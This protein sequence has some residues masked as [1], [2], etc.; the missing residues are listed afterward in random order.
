MTRLI[1]LLTVLLCLYC[2]A[3]IAQCTVILGG[4]AC[5]PIE[6]FTTQAELLAGSTKVNC[7]HLSFKLNNTNCTGWTLKVRTATA[8]F[9]NG[10]N[11][12]P[13]H[14]VSLKFNA[15]TDGPS[16]GTLGY[17]SSP[18]PLST[19]EQSLVSNSPAPLSSP[20]NY[21]FEHLFTASITGGTHM[22]QSVNGSFATTLIFTLYNA[23]NQ[24]VATHSMPFNFQIYY[25]GPNLFDQCQG[26]TLNGTIT[27]P[28]TTFNTYAQIMSGLTKTEAVTVSYGLINNNTN[29]PNWTLKVRAASPNFSNGIQNIPVEKVSLR[30]NNVTGGP[31]A[32]DIGVA[33]NEIP[34]STAD[35]ILINR[36]NARLIAPPHGNVYHR[37]DAIVQGG[38]H[39][40]QPVNGAF[41][42]NLIF[43]LYDW[44]DQLVATWNS[45][46]TIQIYFNGNSLFTLTLQNGANSAYFNFANP[47]DI[48]N[49]ISLTKT[50]GLKITGY[51]NYQVFAQ[52]TNENLVSGSTS[53][54][55]PVSTIKLQASLASPISGVTCNTILLS[56]AS[57]SPLVVNTNPNYPYQT[58]QY[59]LRYYI[60]PNAPAIISSPSGTY[61]GTLVYVVVPY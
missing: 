9:S 49:G 58:V 3:L 20:P 31:S 41:S 43:T 15:V 28:L 2:N 1:T 44:N 32:G 56:S 7:V 53:S 36:S 22:Y 51:Q 46:A 33:Y 14:N 59:N 19:V 48:T 11:A 34:L 30:F 37:W 12:I 54:T 24:L 38:A 10:G 60:D 16:A 21:Y 45:S 25:N 40:L 8:S 5:S 26:M 6:N 4:Y 42:C 18:I 35:R 13:V 52:T 61:T 50:N 29:C 57:Q 55:I 27:N 47:S 39:L 23:S 17:N